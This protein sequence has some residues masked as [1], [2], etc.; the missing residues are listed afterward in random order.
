VAPA[1]VPDLDPALHDTILQWYAEH[2]RGLAFRGTTEPWAILVSEVMAQQTQAARAAA[3]WTGFMA[4]FPTPAALAAASPAAVLRAWRGLGYNRR[5][6]ALRAA[7]ATI[8]ADHGGA[9]PADLAALEALP[10]VGP[11]T[12]RAV[13]ALAFGVAVGAVDTNVRRVLGRAF[14]DAPP[15][16]RE[17]QVFADRAVPTRAP[18][19]WTH[20]LMDIGARLCR[21]RAPRCGECPLAATCRYASSAAHGPRSAVPM[22]RAGPRRR[23]SATP[24]A[25]TPFAATARWLRGRIVDRLRDGADGAWVRIDGPIGDHAPEVV[26]SELDRL[27]AEGLIERHPADRQAAR[28]AT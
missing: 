28:L 7:A 6:L 10:G 24:F 8:V 12:A 13:A 25:A 22:S 17:L 3:A 20:A 26:A 23:G 18:G 21:P 11:Y 14:F 5:A 27:A 15:A 2:G 16:V 1:A 4:A 9:V 19:A